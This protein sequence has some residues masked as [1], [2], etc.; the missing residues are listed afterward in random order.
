MIHLILAYIM[1]IEF[2]EKAVIDE[3]STD[4]TKK[5]PKVSSKKE[6][7]SLLSITE[8]LLNEIND[9]YQ[10]LCI[11]NIDDDNENDNENDNDNENVS[12]LDQAMIN[13]INVFNNK[14]QSKIP[15]PTPYVVSTRSA[16]CKML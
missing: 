4:F 12:D 9:S 2:K 5:T 14:E 15:V 13:Y 8:P 10:S 7:D 16:M 11:N 1:N 3:K 6:K